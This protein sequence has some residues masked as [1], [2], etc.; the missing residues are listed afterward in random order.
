MDKLKDKIKK[1]SR[2]HFE[3]ELPEI[4]CTP[5]KLE[6]EVETGK[7]Y[8]GT[9][10]IE[11]KAGKDMK[12][13]LYSSSHLLCLSV[14]SFVGDKVVVDYEFQAE[15]IRAKDNIKG[16]ISI[17]SSIGEKELSVEV[18]V[19]EKYVEASFGEVK[20][21][22]H[23][24]NLAKINWTKAVTI[25]KSP[26]FEDIF[27]KR[28][29]EKKNLYEGLI[30]SKD[31]NQALEEFLVSIQKKEISSISIE[32][33]LFQYKVKR[34]DVSGV[35]DIVKD[36]WGYL[37]VE[38]EV[39]STQD[40]LI[41]EHKQ[42]TNEMFIGKNCPLQ[43][44][45]KNSQLRSG[46]N[47][48][49]VVFRTMYQQ[50]EVTIVVEKV[51][52][53]IERD[54]DET[55]RKHCQ[56]VLNNGYLNFRSNRIAISDYVEEMRSAILQLDGIEA[57]Q[58]NL[59]EL[60]YSRKLDLY[61]MHL[62][63]V[64][65]AEGHAGEIL[66]SLE[67]EEHILKKNTPVDY[68]GYLYLKALY[69][70]KD[71]DLQTA[72]REIRECYKQ[73][74]K[75]WQ[76]LWFL[77]FLDEKYEREPKEKI[78]DISKQYE[79]GCRSPILYYEICNVLA[80]E[81][82]LLN[83]LT[84][85]LIQ[86]IHMS[87][88]AGMITEGIATQYAYLAEQLKG[89]NRVVLADLV[90]LYEKFQ[91]E[92]LLTAIC[93]ILIRADISDQS[94]FAWYEAGVNA[95]LRLT[96]L[97]EYYIYSIN[98]NYEGLL[99][100][101]VYLYFAK[102][103]DNILEEK[104]AFLF[105]NIVKHKNEIYDIYQIY[106]EQMKAFTRKHLQK[107]HINLEIAVLYREFI[108]EFEVSE[109]IA[110]NLP[111]VL[112]K[113]VIECTHPEIVGVS[114]KHKE[115]QE[116]VYIQ[117]DKR[118]HAYLDIYTDNAA[119]FFVDKAG[120]RYATSI[121]WKCEKLMKRSR[122]AEICYEKAPDNRMLALFIYERMEYYHKRNIDIMDLQCYMDTDWLKPEFKK[123]WIMKLIKSFYDNYEGEALEKLL[124][125]IDLQG[126]RR[127]DRNLVIEYCIIRGLYDLA[128]EQIKEY[129][130]E[131][132]SVKRLRA[133]CS[134]MIKKNGME[135]EDRMLAKMSF[136]VFKAGKYD[137]SILKYLVRFYLGTTKDMFLVWREAREYEM[138]TAELEERL[139]G[140]I[141]FAESYV[142]DAMSV[143]FAFYEKGQNRTLIKAFISY[144]SYKYLIKD[145]VMDEAFFDVVRKE[146]DIEKN[147]TALYALLKYYSTLENWNKE[148]TA[149]IEEEVSEFIKEGIIFPFFKNFAMKIKFMGSIENRCFIEY[150]TNPKHQVKLH[151]FIEDE[152][153]G[154]GFSVEEMKNLYEGIY[155]KNFTLFQNETLQYYIEEIPM[156]GEP[157]IT[158]SITV[159]GDELF[160]EEEEDEFSLINM[161]L[162]AREMKDE[163]TLF[164]LL[165]NYAKNE[166]A[167]QHAF[168]QLD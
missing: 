64:E 53:H 66:E 87:V 3:Y 91:S 68:C 16:T 126:M 75:E 156:D 115:C 149:F 130:F 63:M 42:I 150:K 23:F 122:L 138:D 139:L 92:E 9:F 4:I 142:Q 140:Q 90:A 60:G 10:T 145:R 5:S 127:S 116:E 67:K 102:N 93:S 35:I 27:L 47:F 8:K 14:D 161:M 129:S 123:N 99:P 154:E 114:V 70:R 18:N 49:K 146:L 152:E 84:P 103:T 55:K 78:I 25:F 105:A 26:E 108:T 2:E 134:K 112:F 58:K 41:L 13:L 62:Y 148:Q 160:R 43:F 36:N 72:L 109:E 143:F 80:K 65:G 28:D 117:L 135:Q 17:V 56:M 54:Y 76:M 40:F 30:Q 79:R 133:L 141:L 37:D 1:L 7:C 162:I 94:C 48:A 81:P 100:Q 158:E 121:P 45:I 51:V 157:I 73:N 165:E 136:F 59:G 119:I 69:T 83:E 113:Q 74:P 89:Y 153:M 11:N 38:L 19:V 22:F 88:K 125:E 97:Y 104:K 71:M 39:V 82:T 137:E 33:S 111:F 167:M 44:E 166:Y 61:R 159:H 98:P 29:M 57:V 15:D 12:G 118:R 6:I 86:V 101:E 106:V 107:H 131:G 128:Y 168:K 31:A 163:K 32:K 132:V 95:H 20:D 120:R 21:L 144:Y 151:Y 50:L 46:K 24:T 85:C 34:E 96:Q 155:V 124:L 147:K 110:K 52:K 77:L 164:D